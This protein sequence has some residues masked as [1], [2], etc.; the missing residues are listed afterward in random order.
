MQYH[1]NNYMC[2]QKSCP[3]FVEHVVSISVDIPTKPVI[4]KEKDPT[5]GESVILTCTSTS[6]TTPS[7]HGLKLK[8]I[9]R[10]DGTDN[11]SDSRYSYST[12]KKTFIL[13]NVVKED[14]NKN[15]TC[16]VTEDVDAGYTSS[17]S[18]SVFLNV[19]CKYM[20]YNLCLSS[21]MFMQYAFH[22][23]G[24]HNILLDQWKI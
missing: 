9:W 15:I 10:V 3:Y 18:D 7:N 21:L 17:S 20:F 2:T 24:K 12:N 6:T 8:Y 16:T 13:S 1:L 4:T 11:P 5:V 14:A 23:R 19:L 22:W